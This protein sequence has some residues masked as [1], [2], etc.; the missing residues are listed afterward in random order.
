MK[1]F[2]AVL[3]VLLILIASIPVLA[4]EEP[5]I[6]APTY[7]RDSLTVGNTTRL[8]GRF[9]TE[10]WGNATSDYDVRQLLHGASLVDWGGA[11][12][13]FMLNP[14][15]VTGSAVT[16]DEQGNKTY[17]LV[18]SQT[19]YYSDGSRITAAD[20]AFTLL[21]TV[22]PVIA[23]L[24]GTPMHR[25][26]ILGCSAYAS[27]DSPVLSGVRMLND[28]ALDITL[29]AAYLPFFYELGLLEVTPSPIHV[30]APGVK[31][32]DD[33]EGVYLTNADESV[34]EPQFTAENLARTLLDDPETGNYGYI[35]HPTVVS[36]PY[37][38][39]SF[40]GTTAEFDL[41]PFYKGNHNDETPTIPH[42]TYTLADNATMIDDLKTGKF[43]LLN[44]VARADTVTA[45]LGLL[46]TGAWNVSQYPRSGLS[47]LNFS[48]ERPATSS[49]AVRQA[50]A[51]CMD[52]QGLVQAYVGDN[53]MTVDGWYGM[54]QWMVQV[55]NGTMDY[56]VIDPGEEA[57]EALETQYEAV[58][59]EW[60]TLNMDNIRSYPLDVNQA[61]VYLIADGWTLNRDGKAYQED[62]DDVR[63]KELDGQ[64]VPL[65]L[66]LAYPEG[67]T[68]ADAIETSLIPGAAEAGIQLIL[69]PMGMSALLDQ[70]YR[71]G[72]RTVDLIYMATNFEVL[73]DAAVHF[74][75][76]EEG[77]PIWS[78]TG[79]QDEKLYQFADEMRHTEPADYLTY[80]KHWL[81]FQERFAELLP[82]IPIYSNVY[83]DFYT[84]LLQ[85]YNISSNVSWGQAIV[86]AW[87]GEPAE[88][89]AA[90]EP[91]EEPAAE[92]PA[93]KIGE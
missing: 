48:C 72:E 79:L 41:N 36:G 52:K 50:L 9:F 88:E 71:R 29:D 11:E 26:H 66:T 85:N 12:N 70:L 59:A 89:P 8:D 67:N 74:S 22:D 30:I 38:L 53:G 15:V 28:F 27:G 39:T 81:A 13:M 31:V 49:Q 3:L 40:D 57:S 84:S 51:F 58:I 75:L 17:H 25:D 82:A 43:G 45:G 54:G 6:A 19:L 35:S 33:G 68:I 61:K 69:K 4:E 23:Q 2:A 73:Y 14:Q 78:F 7:P 83:F 60:G 63:C 86:P 37:T 55:L 1:R 21:L 80:I 47:F 34:T 44:K 32:Q 91:S 90:E 64:L 46:G 65:A 87:L 5:Q 16:E 20:Y 42:L 92:E 77:E 18:L 56:P 93:E 76:N 62:V 24:G 10:M